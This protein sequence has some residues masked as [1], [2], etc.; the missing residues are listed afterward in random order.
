VQLDFF[1][2]VYY[3]IETQLSASEVGGWN[4]IR[5][6]RVSV[7]VTWNQQDGFRHW[8]ESAVPALIEYLGKH[9]RIVSFNGDR[10]DSEV[11]SA[12]GDVRPLRAKSLDVMVQIAGIIGHRIT[13][14]SVA[15]ATLGVGK[16]ADGLQ[17]LRWWKEGNL[18]DLTRYCEQ[19]VKVL[20]DIVAHAREHGSILYLDRAGKSQ[21]V[22][23]RL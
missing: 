4:N 21:R 5:A 15:Q 14:D 18:E 16:S 8:N 7:A 19:D 22:P 10:F 23:I 3:D 2:E 6:M 13:L 1:S 12:Y 17:A 20:V 9:D 11:L